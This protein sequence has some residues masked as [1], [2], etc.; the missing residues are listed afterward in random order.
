MDEKIQ[1]NGK[2][3]ILEG[4]ITKSEKREFEGFTFKEYKHYLMKLEKLFNFTDQAISSETALS[5]EK[6]SVL[7]PA[8]VLMVIA[9]TDRA[10]D[11]L[12]NFIWKEEF[13]EEKNVKNATMK[14]DFKS[15]KEELIQSKY[16]N[17]YLVKMLDF[18][19]FDK[20]DGVKLCSG[21][22]YP[23][24]IFN[25]DWEMVLAPRVDND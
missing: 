23:L 6:L 8:N 4:S 25:N 20:Q 13:D 17:E 19:N 15:T 12:K 2:N 9:K 16:S 22:D 7:D 14:L 11:I 5:C 21:S 1:L 24:K 3:Y 10:K 18:F